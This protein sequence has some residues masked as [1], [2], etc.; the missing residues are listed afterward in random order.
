[1]QGQSGD[2]AF[3]SGE[4]DF[5]D[6]SL[7]G[8]IEWTQGQRPL[9]SIAGQSCGIELFQ[10]GDIAAHAGPESFDKSA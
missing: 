9:A 7:D 6:E 8:W 1:M 4:V 5:F 2:S 10:D 3:R